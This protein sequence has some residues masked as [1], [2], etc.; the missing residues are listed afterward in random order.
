[1]LIG[2]EH[3][4]RGVERDLQGLAVARGGIDQGLIDW[5]GLLGMAMVGAGH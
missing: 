2:Y 3:S 4:L 5:T 1:M